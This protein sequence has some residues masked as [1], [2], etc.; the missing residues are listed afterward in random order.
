[1]DQMNAPKN[2]LIASVT[3]SNGLIFLSHIEE[4]PDHP[5]DR[6]TGME[7]YNR[8]MDAKKDMAGLI[9]IAMKLLNPSHL[10]AFQEDLRLY[11][12]EVLAAQ[13]TY[14]KDYIDKWDAETQKRRLTGVAANDCHHNQVFVVKMV[15]E[16]T[17]RFGTI[18]DKEE[19]MRKATAESH[20]GILEM[21]RGKKPG[22]ELA[23]VDWILTIDRSETLAPT[24]SPR[25]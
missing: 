14:L 11:P 24:S 7:I 6:L 13:V 3:A 9:A 2:E 15:D 16:K 1:M 25:N 21:T 12:D 4:R 10:A 22:D 5:M 23:R 18:V 19:D 8:H 20:P 17:V